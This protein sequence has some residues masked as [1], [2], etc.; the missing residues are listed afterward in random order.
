MT[1]TRIPPHSAAHP[2]SI[3]HET[4][5]VEPDG[6]MRWTA[7][8]QD[9]SFGDMIQFRYSVRAYWNMGVNEGFPYTHKMDFESVAPSLEEAKNRCEALLDQ[10]KKLC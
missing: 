1:Y 5:F 9:H 8:I 6:R 7:F 3:S 2:N 10:R 4:G